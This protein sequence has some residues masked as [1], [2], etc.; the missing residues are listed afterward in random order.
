V[1]QAVEDKRQVGEIQAS[2]LIF[3]DTINV[4][5]FKDPKVQPHC[6]LPLRREFPRIAG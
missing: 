6:G 4:E 3:K 1:A 2:G 5:A